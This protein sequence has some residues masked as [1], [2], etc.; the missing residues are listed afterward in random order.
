MNK[1]IVYIGVDIGTTNTKIM[2]INNE[3]CIAYKKSCIT[4]K[5]TKNS[6]NYF[7][8]KAL[9]IFFDN[10]FKMLEK[11]FIIEGISF[12]SVGESVIPIIKGEPIAN[13][14]V[15]NEKCTSSFARE[16]WDSSIKG[17]KYLM[18]S[19]EFNY[20]FSIYKMLYMM[21]KYSVDSPDYWLPLSSYFCFKYTKEAVI[22]YSQASRTF[23]L[24]QEK[25][26]WNEDLISTFNL[27]SK[28]IKIKGMGYQFKN[29]SSVYPFIL[30]GHDHMVAAK[31]INVLTNR[32]TF[33]L[34]SVGTSESVLGITKS[35]K[36]FQN[37]NALSTGLSFNLNR[38]Y[39]L[40]GIHRSGSYIEFLS[41]NLGFDTVSDC[42]NCLNKKIVQ[43]DYNNIK[44]INSILKEDGAIEFLKTNGNPEDMLFSLYVLLSIESKRMIDSVQSNLKEKSDI[45]VVG[46]IIENPVYLSIRA[47]ILNCNINYFKLKELGCYGSIINI[48]EGIG[49]KELINKIINQNR[50]ITVKPNPDLIKKLEL[51]EIKR[52]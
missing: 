23:L 34:D 21:K 36:P 52:K 4:P 12:A 46:N 51:I 25:G 39:C 27:F 31:C 11:E 48:L 2:A 26:K 20:T 22:D 47:S 8:I 18:T 40:K 6:E 1:E 17:K 19:D 14:L 43:D 13:S 32:T 45:I 3:N 15:W 7:D 16:I 37:N 28:D 35:S 30:G 29:N 38:P 24:D 10:T 42:V 50:I 33:V 44:F 5:Y 49:N 41:K 9:E